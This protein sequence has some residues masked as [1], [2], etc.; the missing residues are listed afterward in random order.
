MTYTYGHDILKSIILRYTV[1]YRACV[2]TSTL[3]NYTMLFHDTFYTV[4]LQFVR[5]CT[6]EH[7]RLTI[8]DRKPYLKSRSEGVKIISTDRSEIIDSDTHSSLG[9]SNN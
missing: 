8:P 1:Y 4:D 7:Y 6:K 2:C 5:D 9:T 3:K